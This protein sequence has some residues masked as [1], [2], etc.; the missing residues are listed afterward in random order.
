MKRLIILTIAIVL[1]TFSIEA[2][3]GKSLAALKKGDKILKWKNGYDKLVDVKFQDYLDDSFSMDVIKDITMKVLVKAK[4]KLK[5]RLTFVPVK[6]L[7][8][9]QEDTGE[10]NAIVEFLGK[11]AYGV[12]GKSTSY[13]KFDKKGEVEHLFTR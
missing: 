7:L 1:T 4:F 2:Q 8:L 13:F 5:N 10:N 3:N 11:N 6:V 12:E 9:T